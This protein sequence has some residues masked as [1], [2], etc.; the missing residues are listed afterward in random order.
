MNVYQN[1]LSEKPTPKTT[2]IEATTEIGSTDMTTSGPT[3]F[4]N[5]AEITSE[6]MTT[7]TI[8]EDEWMGI[9]DVWLRDLPPSIPTTITKTTPSIISTTTT[10]TTTTTVQYIS[11]IHI[12]G[13]LPTEKLY[14]C[15]DGETV[16]KDY[17]DFKENIE[18]EIKSIFEFNSL[19][20]S[21]T[22]SVTDIQEFVNEENFEFNSKRRKRSSVMVVIKYISA[23]SVQVPTPE[24]KENTTFVESLVNDSIQNADANLWVNKSFNKES[25]SASLTFEQPRIIEFKPLSQTDIQEKIGSFKF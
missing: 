1:I 12:S 22:V 11:I 21:A 8:S 24:D 2:T 13:S 6:S 25:F 20:E 15:E 7:T 16:C 19:V 4:E 18:S 23:C 14:D 9:M 10:T 5:T 17:F 3:A